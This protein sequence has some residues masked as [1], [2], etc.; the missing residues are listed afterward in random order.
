MKKKGVFCIECCPLFPVQP[1]H[2]TYIYKNGSDLRDEYP[3]RERFFL[4]LNEII[5]YI[6]LL[7]S[8]A[9][10][11]RLPRLFHLLAEIFREVPTNAAPKV[12]QS[13]VLLR[14]AVLLSDHLSF[15]KKC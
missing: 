4:E 1:D 13:I 10:T 12:Q 3:Y 11:R 5:Q 14:A 2:C 15:A 6:A 7:D 9:A 8:H